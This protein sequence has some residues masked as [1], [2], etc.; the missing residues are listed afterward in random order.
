M[1]DPNEILYPEAKF[2][3]AKICWVEA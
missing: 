3:S 1:G 2:G